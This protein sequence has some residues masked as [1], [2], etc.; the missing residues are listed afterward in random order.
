MKPT[1]IL[2]VLL[3]SA[4]P[5]SARIVSAWQCGE[6]DVELHKYATKAFELRF[7]GTLTVWSPT[8]KP[9]TGVNFKYVGRNGAILNGKPC[10]VLPYDPKWDQND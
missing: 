7:S 2:L 8:G 1:A 3:I 4:A 9:T 10:R 6:V 5:A